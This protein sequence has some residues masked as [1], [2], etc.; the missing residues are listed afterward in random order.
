M[1]SNCS[2]V[3]QARMTSSRLPGK[4]LKE[5]LGKPLLE[6]QI[7]RLRK[8]KRAD[9]IVIATTDLPSD[10]PVFAL[11]ERLSV[12]CFR[13]PE[14][15]VLGRYYGAIETYPSK[16][17]VRS[18]ADCP[19]I[20]PN[21]VDAVIGLYQDGG[22]DYASNTLTRSFPRGLDCE[23][24]SR[25]MLET[26]LREGKKIYER[27]HVTPYFYQHPE[28]YRLGCLKNSEDQSHHRWTVDT[29]EDFELISKLIAAL[30]PTNPDFRMRDVL[31]LFKIHPDWIKINAHVEQKPLA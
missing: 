13:G 22:Y 9:Q 8:V 14:D 30:Y 25:K 26:A 23:V 29:A 5:V 16:I 1:E 24:F 27:E 7:E 15:D 12:L 6:Y 17:V 31:A 2:I 21:I 11:S 20:D 19:L 4:I 10:D 28:L 18:T 3:V